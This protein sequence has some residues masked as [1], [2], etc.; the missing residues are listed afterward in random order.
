MR[1]PIRLEVRS[2]PT[3]VLATGLVAIVLT[4]TVVGFIDEA[5]RIFVDV[6]LLLVALYAAWYSLTRTGFRRLVEVTVIPRTVVSIRS[7]IAARLTALPRIDCV[8]PLA[9]V[10][11]VRPRFQ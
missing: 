8:P 4:A 3:V 11:L 6:P 9:G 7:K 1:A 5:W 10:N 2:R